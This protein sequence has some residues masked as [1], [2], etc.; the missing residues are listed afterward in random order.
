MIDKKV[1][2][3]RLKI[4]EQALEE[5]ENLRKDSLE[6]I[7]NSLEKQWAVEHGLQLAIQTLLDIGSHILV[8]EG[9]R[10]INN[11]TDIIRQLGEMGIISREFAK[12]IEG[13]AG[14]RNIL[15][16]EYVDVDLGV[17]FKI[18]QQRLEDFEK[19]ISFI[20]E[21]LSKQS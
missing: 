6:D 2:Q 16:H 19:F 11:Y 21:Y 13:M 5:L 14:L 20:R 18:L 7:Q 4:L 3:K 8:E 9:E 12:S 10:D 1:I 17:I 15:V